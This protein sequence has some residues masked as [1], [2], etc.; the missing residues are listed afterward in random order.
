MA[1]KDNTIKTAHHDDHA[2]FLCYD[3][4]HVIAQQVLL[5]RDVSTWGALRQCNRLLWQTLLW[6]DDPRIELPSEH[7]H[8]DVFET[9]NRDA[10][11]DFA[12][13]IA[14]ASHI[15]EIE[16]NDV[17][18]VSIV[19]QVAFDFGD[20][21]CMDYLIDVGHKTF[22]MHLLL[23]FGI[24]SGFMHVVEWVFRRFPEEMTRDALIADY[25][26]QPSEN[27]D[28]PMVQYLLLQQMHSD[29]VR[30]E[31]ARTWV[32]RNACSYGQTAL[33]QWLLAADNPLREEALQFYI[34][35]GASVIRSV[36][37]L[38]YLPILNILLRHDVPF[39]ATAIQA[40]LLRSHRRHFACLRTLHR[41]LHLCAI[42]EADGDAHAIQQKI[43]R[44]HLSSLLR[45]CIDWS[46]EIHV[47]L[48]L[49]TMATRVPSTD[50]ANMHV[51]RMP[52]RASAIVKNE[53]PL[54]AFYEHYPD[55]C[56]V[57]FHTL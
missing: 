3:V 17:C 41:H 53:R 34:T 13:C 46:T 26:D 48:L 2:P 21:A 55:L 42:G 9:W 49:L 10:L 14:H 20:T 51:N 25:V 56:G 47:P 37:T 4:L 28:I 32:Y 43:F 24:C 5:L 29:R 38:G 6:P 33:L 57:S 40:V 19:E 30:S 45:N 52:G 36:V 44:D 8:R 27:G 39:D 11:M 31:K 18:R 23:S 22:S 1:E 15:Q 12:R 7:I 54:R 50:P 35:H 16:W